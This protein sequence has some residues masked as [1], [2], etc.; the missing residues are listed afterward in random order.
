MS[1]IDPLIV[2]L[3]VSLLASLLA[4]VHDRSL[5]RPRSPVEP[6]S[7][8]DTRAE[9]SR[10]A[11]G[12]VVLRAGLG[13]RGVLQLQAQPTPERRREGLLETLAAPRVEELV[14]VRVG[15]PA[16]LETSLAIL[17]SLIKQP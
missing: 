1:P 9:A 12:E 5:P 13:P 17:Q 3:P 10:H 4:P 7:L 15:E 2:S 8:L 11:L 16:E 6:D 14:A